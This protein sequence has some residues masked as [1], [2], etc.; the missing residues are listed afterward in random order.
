M[1]EVG[2]MSSKEPM[3]VS[4]TDLKTETE[5][6]TDNNNNNNNSNNNSKNN[7]EIVGQGQDNRNKYGNSSKRNGNDFQRRN[8]NNRSG[9]RRNNNNNNRRNG[10]NRQDIT[11]KATLYVNGFI[12]GTS[13]KTLAQI[14]EVYGPLAQ[15]NVLPPRQSDGEQYAFVAFRKIYDMNHILEDIEH[16]K[17]LDNGLAINPAKGISCE[18]ARTLP[19]SQRHIERRKTEIKDN[20]RDVG[21][22]G[23]NNV[24]NDYNI[25]DRK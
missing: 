21:I 3:Q 11:P 20:R 19:V 14:F 7:S 24:R 5:T 13:A 23:Y 4:N 16:G 18:K 10:I 25:N 12:K 1:N 6:K 2:D 15:V 8:M 17:I 22:G 9:N